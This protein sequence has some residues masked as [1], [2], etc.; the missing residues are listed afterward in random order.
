MDLG[1]PLSAKYVELL[2]GT[3]SVSIEVGAG[4]EVAFELPA[5]LSPN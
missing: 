5:D 4:T 2:G 3:L 1:L